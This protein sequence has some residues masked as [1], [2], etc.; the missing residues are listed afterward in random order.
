[1]TGSCASLASSRET[2]ETHHRVSAPFLLLVAHD[3]VWIRK[4]DQP[5]TAIASAGTPRHLNTG[6]HIVCQGSEPPAL[7]VPPA[8]T[9]QPAT[10]A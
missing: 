4:A 5:V 1:M 6:N 9:H 3:S 10:G 2:S 7:P 8:S